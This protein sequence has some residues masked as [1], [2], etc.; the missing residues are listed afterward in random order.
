MRL[1]KI[2]RIART[3]I[4]MNI[5]RCGK[6]IYAIKTSDHLDTVGKC[7]NTTHAYICMHACMCVNMSLN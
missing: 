5:T 7:L 3:F 6:V 2:K 4:V 1:F